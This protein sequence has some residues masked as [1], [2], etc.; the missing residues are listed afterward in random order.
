MVASVLVASVEDLHWR[1]LSKNRDEGIKIQ[2]L[3]HGLALKKGNPLSL[4]GM[5]EEEEEEEEE[6]VVVASAVVS[7]YGRKQKK[8]QTK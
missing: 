6:E 4:N 7:L 8:T 1:N 3:E 2:S 5:S